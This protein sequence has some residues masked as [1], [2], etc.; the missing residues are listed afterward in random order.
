MT[1]NGL[2][3]YLKKPK[4][5]YAYFGDRGLLRW[6]SDKAY[7]KLAFRMEMGK[8]LDLEN[9]KTYNEKLQWLKI[10]DRKPIYTTMVDKYAVKKLIAEK[11]GEQYVIPTLGVWDSFDDIDFDSLPH[12]F[13]LKCTHDS[14][15]LV[16]CRDKSK[17]DIDAAR[18]KINKFLK[19]E[20]FWGKREWPYK[21]VPPRIIAE[22]YMEDEETAELRDYKFFCFNGSMEALFIATDRQVPG[23]EVKFD[24]FDK[25]C[26]RLPLKQGHQNAKNL[27]KMP[28]RFN[29]MKTLAEIL[30][31]DIPHVRI[32]FYEV[33]GKVYFG[34][35]TFYHFSGLVPFE[36]EEWDYTFGSWITLPNKETTN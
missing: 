32:D 36:P 1:L 31:K 24:F 20:Y 16:I 14:G 15:G 19:R 5:I 6:M 22:Q 12:Q 21:D 17:L 26:E 9:P 29:E 11:I 3:G 8:K 2:K 18:K 35:M 27:P 34:E 28:G 25:N 13:V 7:L 10:Y 30:S 23:E 4:K 33:N